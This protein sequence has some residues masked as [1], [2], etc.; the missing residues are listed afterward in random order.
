MQPSYEPNYTLWRREGI[1]YSGDSALSSD[2]FFSSVGLGLIAAMLIF[3]LLFAETQAVEFVMFFYYNL[4]ST[5]QSR[6]A[7][8][9]ASPVQ[10]Q[11]RR[12]TS[13]GHGADWIHNIVVW[14]AWS[15]V[16]VHCCC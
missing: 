7:F 15:A 5:L 13:L 1:I 2:N 8:Q 12:W 10:G 11:G 16:H 9:I 4:H 14:P 3:I 6:A